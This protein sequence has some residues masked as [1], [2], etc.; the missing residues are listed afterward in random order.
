MTIS[1]KDMNRKELEALRK[2]IDMRLKKLKETDRKDA[3]AAA[4]KAAKAHG[5]DLGELVVPQV[6]KRKKSS[7]PKSTSV[8]KY[9]NPDDKYQTWTGKGRQPQWFKAALAKGVTPEQLEIKK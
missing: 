3:I 4:Q 1:L 9:E 6:P 2:R 5:F 7:K 8:A